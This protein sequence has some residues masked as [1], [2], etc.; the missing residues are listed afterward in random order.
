MASNFLSKALEDPSS[1]RSS[2][3]SPMIIAIL[4]WMGV[5]FGWVFNGVGVHNVRGLVLVLCGVLKEIFHNFKIVGTG[6]KKC[7][8]L[9]NCR[10][11]NS[12]TTY[13]SCSHHPN[14][15]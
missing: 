9:R 4:G 8:V 6:P 13:G 11:A 1:N 10:E 5:L 3:P 15:L 7:G 14:I 12:S 2:T